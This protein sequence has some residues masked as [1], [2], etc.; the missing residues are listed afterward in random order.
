[1]R[2]QI[3]HEIYTR[4]EEFEPDE[5]FKAMHQLLQVDG[6]QNSEQY[7]EQDAEQA[8]EAP[9]DDEY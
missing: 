5:R 4:I 6:D 1:M 3:A 7:A 2:R 9:L 8:D